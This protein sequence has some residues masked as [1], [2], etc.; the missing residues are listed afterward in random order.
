MRDTT[1]T[2]ALSESSER[3]T[4]RRFLLS[5]AGRQPFVCRYR[6]APLGF[7]LSRLDGHPC[8]GGFGGFA[9]LCP[10]RF[11][12]VAGRTPIITGWIIPLRNSTQKQEH[13]TPCGK[14][15]GCTGSRGCSHRYQLGERMGQQTLA[16]SQ[17]DIG[18]KRHPTTA[19]HDGLH[20]ENRLLP[21]PPALVAGRFGMESAPKGHSPIAHCPRKHSN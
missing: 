19:G 16:L 2:T 21:A 15:D 3:N 8:S 7:N 1:H 9:C 6:H 11:A 17:T 13:P 14:K 12:L 4:G 20:G 10:T 18:T 5:G